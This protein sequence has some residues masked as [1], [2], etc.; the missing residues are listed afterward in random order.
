M[1]IY[2]DAQQTPASP[3]KVYVCRKSFGYNLSRNFYRNNKKENFTRM[4][5]I[6]F[7]PRQ[8]VA[9]MKALFFGHFLLTPKESVIASPRGIEPLLR[10]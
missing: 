4:P 7:M 5:E 3:E 10:E 9:S 6:P 1:G 2:H 8:E